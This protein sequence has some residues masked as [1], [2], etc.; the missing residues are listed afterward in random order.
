MSVRESFE[1]IKDVFTANR[2]RVHGC[3]SIV[4]LPST[5]DELGIGVDG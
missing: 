5:W 2:E 1:T 3:V 4:V